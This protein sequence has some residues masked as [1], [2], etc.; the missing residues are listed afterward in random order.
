MIW[1]L[2]GK[3][4]NQLCPLESLSEC[5]QAHLLLLPLLVLQALLQEQNH[6]HHYRNPQSFLLISFQYFILGVM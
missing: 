1:F 6:F 4:G 5:Q 2:Q 3:L